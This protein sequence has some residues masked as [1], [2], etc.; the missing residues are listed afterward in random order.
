MRALLPVSLGCFV[1]GAVPILA[2]TFFSPGIQTEGPWGYGVAIF[3]LTTLVFL[4]LVAVHVPW[5]WAVVVVQSALVALLFYQALSDA[6]L[7]IGT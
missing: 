2:L 3:G 5:V 1:V 4:S 7:Y 6:A